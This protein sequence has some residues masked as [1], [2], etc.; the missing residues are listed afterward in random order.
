MK[1]TDTTTPSGSLVLIDG[2]SLLYRAFFALPP[3][4]NAQGEVTNAAYGFTMMLSKVLE[5]EQPDMVAVAFDLPGPT[6]RH[7]LFEEYKATRRAMPD[8]LAPQIGMTRE[9]LAARHIP[10]YEMPG[11]EADDVIGTL[12][13]QAE[14][15]GH[16]VLIVTGDLDELQLV[17][18]HI[19]VMLTRRGITDTKVYDRA[20]VEER[21]GLRPEQLVDFRALRGDTTD[22]IPGVPG[23]GEKTATALIAEYGSL[24]ELLARAEEVK[25]PRIG[26]AL[27]AHAEVA[28]RAKN[29]SVIVRD[30]PIE[31][32]PEKLRRRPPDEQKLMELFR[33]LDF[34]TLVKRLE[35]PT[36]QQAQTEEAGA[37]SK[38]SENYRLVGTV[39]EAEAL[40]RELAGKD[41]RGS[42]TPPY[43]TAGGHPPAARYPPYKY[44]LVL[45]PIAKDGSGIRTPL[46]GLGL[47][48]DSEPVVLMTEQEKLADLLAP[49][50]PVLE[51]VEVGKVGHDLKRSARL[52][53]EQGVELRGMGFDTMIAAH[54][55]NPARKVEELSEVVY[56]Y[57]A[58]ESPEK[59]GENP[60]E[61]CAA[62]VAVRRITE[63]KQ[64]LEAQLEAAELVRVFR[65]LEMPLIPVLVEM[66]QVGVAVDCEALAELSHKL[67][68]RAAELEQDIHAIAGEEFNI[69]SPV[70]LR[71]ILFEKLGLPPDKT[72]RTKTGYSTGAD[73]LAGLSEYE[74]VTKI[75]EYREVTKLKS[76]YVDALPPL[77]N[78]KTG[79]IHTS[80][81]QAVTAT[82]RLSS[83][84]PNLQNI[85]IRTEAG[86]EIRRCFVT[87]SPEHVLLSADY[88][89]IELRI[90]A[91]ITEDENLIEIFQKD[92]DLH[93]AAAAEIF[94][95]DP[96]NVM[97]QMRAFA[98]MVNFGIPYGISDFRL[99]REMGIPQEE[100]RSYMERYFA[101]FPKVRQYVEEMPVRAREQGYVQTLMGRKRPLPELRTRAAPLRQAAE[102]MAINTPMQGS[103]AEIIKVAMLRV[104]AGLRERGLRGKMILQVHDELVLEAPERE[105]RETALLVGESMTTA[106]ELRV[107]LKVEM[108]VGRNWLVMDPIAWR[109]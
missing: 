90:L 99:A 68:A 15:A 88:S 75:L 14:Q 40:A 39:A 92:E 82:G 34:R 29:L 3:L 51:S 71:H 107:P 81:N 67:G 83:T 4:T 24:E 73:V 69:G 109:E 62:A 42:T 64:L 77:V 97:P 104:H 8:E 70:Q 31:F 78:P 36:L 41:R 61:P 96:Q 91:H 28:R 1:E 5:E 63:L 101:R 52:L 84:N 108:K 55:M 20:A 13:T 47:L 49:L 30:L 94:R 74:I 10:I 89:Q 106:Y 23:V 102:R 105:L 43:S 37:P 60:A 100:A 79:R 76:T 80:F 25:P 66:E 17:S 22:N 54:L 11:Y 57:L 95:V 26:A 59:A 98:K 18:D 87:G 35:S 38:V 27:I 93:R 46:L 48:A 33:R 56:D 16:R 9:I 2:N 19:L 72:K 50:K 103:A 86:M 58:G 85:P 44:E 7:D 6:F 21:Y 45:H 32:D 65:E 12:A 53:S